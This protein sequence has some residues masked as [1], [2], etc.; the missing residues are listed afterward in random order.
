MISDRLE[1]AARSQLAARVDDAAAAGVARNGISADTLMDMI[2]G[3]AWYAVCV[4]HVTNT[5]RAAEELTDLVL[6]GVLSTCSPRT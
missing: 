4:R 1:A 6:N 3:A 2:A 5:D